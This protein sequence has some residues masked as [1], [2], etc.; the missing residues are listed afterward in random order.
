MNVQLIDKMGSDLSV[1]NAARVS[2]AKRKELLDE[3]WDELIL[4]QGRGKPN[5]TTLQNGKEYLRTALAAYCES[6]GVHLEQT[7][8]RLAFEAIFEAALEEEHMAV[9]KQI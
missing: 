8:G 9:F 7:A 6:K 4:F 2:F 5:L 1:V 3:K